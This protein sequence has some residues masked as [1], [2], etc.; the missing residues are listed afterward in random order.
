MNIHDPD[1]VTAR[2]DGSVV[3]GLGDAAVFRAL[4]EAGRAVG[5]E[6]FHERLLDVVRLIVPAERSQ[7][8][9]YFRF[10]PP[11]MWATHGIPQP[12]MDLYLRGYYRYDPFLQHWREHGACAV[13]TLA[14]VSSP[15]LAREAYVATFLSKAGLADEVG[16]HLPWVGRSTVVLFLERTSSRFSPHEA[17]LLKA[18]YPALHGL[19]RAHISK[20][21]CALG[22]GTGR[23]S[24]RFHAGQA[25]MIV[26]ARG[27]Q[28]FTSAAWRKRASDP[29]IAAALKAVSAEAKPQPRL[30]RS[31][32]L[33]VELLGEA[34]P[35]APGGRVYLLD[36]RRG[37]A[38]PDLSDELITTV[39][40]VP[41]TPRE[42]QIVRFILAGYPRALIAR[43]LG[44][45]VGTVKNHRLRLYYKM[46]ITSERELLALFLRF[47][48]TPGVG[49]GPAG[50]AIRA[51]R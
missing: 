42:I 38:Q 34:A 10:A 47:F 24:S 11:R 9:Q 12:L 50:T 43:A 27:E 22:G 30:G 51:A 8:V 6:E 23:R 14:D 46:D 5:S 15:R 44:V 32:L 16:V 45:T 49:A 20:L 33:H 39:C 19:N 31:W 28:I 29:D 4:G 7:V 40:G 1:T 36:D 41:L 48:A 25:I 18:L 35:L 2:L 37:A 17:S 26:D 21:F 3:V 13:L